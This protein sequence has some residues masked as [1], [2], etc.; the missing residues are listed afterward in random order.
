MLAK[1]CIEEALRYYSKCQYQDALIACN[2]AIQLVPNYS[3]A[4]HG[5]GLILVQQQKYEEALANYRKACELM[6]ERANIHA[7][8]AKLLYILKDYKNSYQS[9]TKAIRIDSKYELLYREK[10]RELI[11]EAFSALKTKIINMLFLHSVQYFFLTQEI[12]EQ[13]SSLEGCEIS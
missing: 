13:S 2:Q 10:L 6:P 12:L 4:Y 3:R 9:F 1:Q 8:M 11:E 5:K 7:E